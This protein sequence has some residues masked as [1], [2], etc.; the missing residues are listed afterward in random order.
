MTMATEFTV[1]G[2][3][4]TSFIE[5][6]PNMIGAIFLLLLGW[7]LGRIVAE[8]LRK[9][10]KKLKAEKYFKVDKGIKV[11]E[12]FCEVIKWIIYLTFITAA[13]DVLEIATLTMYLNELNELII[14]LIGGTVVIVVSYLI[15][16]YAQKH[17]KA[18][19]KEYS[20]L[21]AKLIFIFVMVI[22]ISIA[23]EVAG[24]PNDLI[25]TIIIIS[26]ASIGLGVAIALGLGLKDTVARLAKKYEKKL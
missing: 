1:L 7:L 15:G 25:N 6:L 3:L 12:I 13:V 4:A 22:A 24:I 20:G 9:L 8:L 23:F 2:N 26:V 10:F 14:G 16:R 18:S 19:K 11:T 17:V 21:M 5:L